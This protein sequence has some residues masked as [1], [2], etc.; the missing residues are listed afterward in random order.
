MRVQ[1][2]YPKQVMRK[3]KG[4]TV[5]SLDAGELAALCF[6]M[7]KSRMYGFE[8]SVINGAKASDLVS[9]SNK[10]AADAI[11]ANVNSRIYLRVA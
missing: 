4:K 3:L 11:L 10:E 7:R 5:G 6:F 2:F 8:I 1:K 9:A